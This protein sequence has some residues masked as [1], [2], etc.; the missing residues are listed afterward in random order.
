MRKITKAYT[1]FLVVYFVLVAV[2]FAAWGFDNVSWMAYQSLI[3][4]L[5]GS[6]SI[7]W[8]YYYMKGG[9]AYNTTIKLN[10]FI[11]KKNFADYDTDRMVRDMG[12]YMI[13]MGAL[14]ILGSIMFY[15]TSNY[16]IM[17]CV[18]LFVIAATIAFFIICR[19]S[20]YLKK[21]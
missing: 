10:F 18:F 19:R 4:C 3:W 7:Y 13:I 5:F 21:Y 1:R 15:F 16:S 8:G 2:I 11:R 17:L 20:K 6:V 9:E 12:K 14:V